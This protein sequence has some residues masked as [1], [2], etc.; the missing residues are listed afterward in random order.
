MKKSKRNLKSNL[1]GKSAL[2]RTNLQTKNNKRF[3]EGE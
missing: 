3:M 2:L 1:A